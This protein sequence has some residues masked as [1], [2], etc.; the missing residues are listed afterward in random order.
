[1]EE[2]TA[3]IDTDADKETGV[4]RLKKKEKLGVKEKQRISH[5]ARTQLFKK[6]MLPR[7]IL[8]LVHGDHS[9]NPNCTFGNVLGHSKDPP[10]VSKAFIKDKAAADRSQLRSLVRFGYIV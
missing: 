10:G 5:C 1:M 9:A 4:T 7:I 8:I 2:K 6:G 3:R